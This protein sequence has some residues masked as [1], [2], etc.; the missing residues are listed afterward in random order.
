MND[1]YLSHFPRKLLSSPAVGNIRRHILSSLENTL[2]N[3]TNQEPLRL[4]RRVHCHRIYKNFTA[5]AEKYI[6]LS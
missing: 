4:Q 6:C 1:T 5:T 2:Q 3:S